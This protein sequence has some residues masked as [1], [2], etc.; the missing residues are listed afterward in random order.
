MKIDRAYIILIG[1]NYI[2]AVQRTY[3]VKL[4]NIF[5]ED[6]SLLGFKRMMASSGPELLKNAISFYGFDEKCATHLQLW[7]RAELRSDGT[8]R[9]SAS[10]V[11]LDTMEIIPEEYEFVW[12][13]GFNP[14]PLESLADV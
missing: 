5:V 11:R 8:H 3:Y 2:M 7:S 10:T 4:D 12:V 1:I 14:P 6:I 13:R 9:L